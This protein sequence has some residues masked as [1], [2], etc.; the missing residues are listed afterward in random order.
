MARITR[1]SLSVSIRE[2]RGS[3]LLL[4]PALDLRLRDLDLGDECNV[5]D[6]NPVPAVRVNSQKSPVGRD[7]GV[8][9]SGNRVTAAVGQ[10][11]GKWPEWSSGHS[12]FDR[13]LCHVAS[14]LAPVPAGVPHRVVT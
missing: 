8:I 10:A 3:A 11:H 2:I 12:L 9:G 14:T 13:F 7:A 6:F 1:I 5:E 4:P